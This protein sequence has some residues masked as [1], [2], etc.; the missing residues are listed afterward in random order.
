[1]DKNFEYNSD[2]DIIYIYNTDEPMQTKGSIICNNLVF[3]IS[4]SGDI[5]GMQ[6]EDASKFL[7]TTPQILKQI[8]KAEIRILTEGKALVIAYKIFTKQINLINT[9]MLPKNR[10]A[11]TH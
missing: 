1:M 9:F 4:P 3:D 8:K 11:L 10:I 6:I 5:V 2:Q 7:N